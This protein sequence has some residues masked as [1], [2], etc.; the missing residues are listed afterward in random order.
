MYL[1]REPVSKKSILVHDCGRCE[2][3][4]QLSVAVMMSTGPS[5]RTDSVTHG[6]QLC[7]SDHF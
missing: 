2:E 5:S 4:H 7:K 6:V 1:M 3:E